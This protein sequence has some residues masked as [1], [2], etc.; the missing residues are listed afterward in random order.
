MLVKFTSPYDEKDF[1]VNPDHVRSVHHQLDI[2]TTGESWAFD[3]TSKRIAFHK[4]GAAWICTGEGEGVGYEAW[5]TL[6][7]V[8]A[9]LN[10][11]RP[12]D[13]DSQLFAAKREGMAE[14]W[15]GAATHPGLPE[16]IAGAFRLAAK[17]ML[18]S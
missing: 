16:A 10:G 9:K 17:R 2:V 8:A 4:A 3:G 15:H 6:D 18:Q 1:F 13:I 11:N 7:E 12:S 14:A 5:G